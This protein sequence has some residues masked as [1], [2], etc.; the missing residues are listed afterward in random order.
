MRRHPPAGFIL[1]IDIS[2]RLLV[3]V[4]NAEAFGGFVGRFKALREAAF[5][6]DRRAYREPMRNRLL[7]LAPL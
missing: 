1:E 6:T 3:G 5:S 2:K 4:A 7:F